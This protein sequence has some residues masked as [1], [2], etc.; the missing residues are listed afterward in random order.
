MCDILIKE[1]GE[2]EGLLKGIV[3]RVKD[4]GGFGNWKGKRVFRKE[5]ELVEKKLESV[6]KLL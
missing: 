1:L 3:R 6:R 5:I 4:W 2:A